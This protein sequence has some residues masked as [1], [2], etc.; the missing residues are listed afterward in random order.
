MATNPVQIPISGDSSGYIT[1]NSHAA[2]YQRVTLNFLNNQV[3]FSGSGEGVPMTTQTGSP[4]YDLGATR[5]NYS[6]SALFQFSTSG[7]NGPFQ[8]A[9]SVQDPII[10]QDGNSTFITVTSEDS[11]DNDNNDSYLIIFYQGL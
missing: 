11:S 9:V 2:Y 4:L 7:P 3:I 10:S 8:N 6:I 5:Q 1:C